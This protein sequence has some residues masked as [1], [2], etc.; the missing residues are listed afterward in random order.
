MENQETLFFLDS[1]E[2]ALFKP[3]KL[4]KNPAAIYLTKLSKDARRVQKDALNVIAGMI[5]PDL[6]C[7]TVPWEHLEYQHAQAIRSVLTERY[8]HTTVNRIL[9]ALRETIKQAWLLGLVPAERYLRIKQVENV[10]GS[11]LPAGRQITSGEIKAVMD[12]CIEDL[13]PA[14]YRD[15][16]I[17]SWMVSGGGPRRSEVVWWI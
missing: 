9:S 13:S 15:A 10:K 12:V 1:S 11:K 14:G 8:S 2:K 4:D 3:Q 17:I 16:A 7:L 5:Y 6:D